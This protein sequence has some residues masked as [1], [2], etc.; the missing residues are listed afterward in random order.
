MHLKTKEDFPY[1]EFLTINFHRTYRCLFNSN[2]NFL[3]VEISL[4]QTKMKLNL[5]KNIRMK[6]ENET[7]CGLEV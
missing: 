1:G 6:H 4:L 2:D 5:S 3:I 7:Y